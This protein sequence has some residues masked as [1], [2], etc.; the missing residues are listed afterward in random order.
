MSNLTEFRPE[1]VICM[2]QVFCYLWNLTSV[3]GLLFINIPCG[4]EKNVYALIVKCSILFGSVK[5]SLLVMVSRFSIALLRFCLLDLL[6]FI[7]AH[8]NLL[9]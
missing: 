3:N 8:K 1:E 7:V 2:K 4:F 5:S 9:I 6:L